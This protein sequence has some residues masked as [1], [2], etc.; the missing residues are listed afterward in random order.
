MRLFHFMHKR[1]G[2]SHGLA[3]QWY[4]RSISKKLRLHESQR[5]RL[6]ALQNSIVSSRAYLAEIHKDRSHLLDEIFNNDGFDREA[7]LHYLN[8]PRLAFEEQAPAVIDS[9]DEF[10]QCLN[11]EQR[12]QLRALL[13]KQQQHRHCWH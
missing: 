11:P 4:L 12:Q 7:A 6:S 3:S 2:R 1:C 5:A 13:Y 9:L 10:Y 8:V